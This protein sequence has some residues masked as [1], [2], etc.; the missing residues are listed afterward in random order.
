MNSLEPATPALSS[1]KSVWDFFPLILCINLKERDDRLREASAEFRKV[2]LERVIFYRTTRQADRAKGCTDSHMECLKYAVDREVPYVLIFEDDVMFQ[3]GFEV[4]LRNSIAFLEKNPDWKCFYLGGLI[5]RKTARPAPGIVKGAILC[6]QAYVVKTALA[7]ELLARR[8]FF[9]NKL[10][11]V[12]LFYT[13][14][15]WNSALFHSEPLICTQRPSE[16]DGTWDA[17]KVSKSGWLGKAMIYA[18]LDR[19]GR[20]ETKI[21]SSLEKFNL[22]QGLIFFRVYRTYLF[23]QQTVFAAFRKLLGKKKILQPPPPGEFVDLA[24]LSSTAVAKK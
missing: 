18:A 9:A 10:V 19:K 12:D 21:L 24:S 14:V 11:S 1:Q 15:I 20:R 23:I 6:T 4:N 3:E 13:M 17:R 5:F 16:S 7:K 22:E 8:G 2:G